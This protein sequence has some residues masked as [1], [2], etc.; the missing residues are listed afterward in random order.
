MDKSSIKY[1]INHLAG[2]RDNS[3]FKA[4]VRCS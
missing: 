3:K 1:F 2:M 4:Q